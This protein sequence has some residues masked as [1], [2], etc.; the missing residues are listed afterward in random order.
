MIGPPI[1][2]FGLTPPKEIDILR[3][4][5][6]FDSTMSEN[7]KITEIVQRIENFYRARR[8]NIRQTEAIRIKT[9]RLFESFEK[10]VRKR[11]TILKSTPEFN[12]QNIFARN[13]QVVFD[14]SETIR[15]IP[16]QHLDHFDDF[17]ETN[18]VE[19][20]DCENP[21]GDQEG[22]LWREKKQNFDSK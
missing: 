21:P 9:K 19:S 16:N 12:R 14:V 17:C 13:I 15:K 8:I 11:K 10:L 5:C 7:T 6:N 4:Y 3:L 20:S 1:E 18:S 22:L 2:H